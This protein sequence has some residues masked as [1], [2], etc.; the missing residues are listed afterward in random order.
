L[1]S[2]DSMIRKLIE[3]T[4]SPIVDFCKVSIGAQNLMYN[5]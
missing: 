4:C 1:E 5:E 2:I 3:S